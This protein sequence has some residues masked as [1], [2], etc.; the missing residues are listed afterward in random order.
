VEEEAEADSA[1]DTEQDDVQDHH[2]VVAGGAQGEE[3][4]DGAEG[5]GDGEVDDDRGD[6][7]AEHLNE[8]EAGSDERV[9]DVE[10]RERDEQG[11]DEEGGEL[12]HSGDELLPAL[13]GVL[14]PV[15][16]EGVPAHEEAV[17]GAEAD[18]HGH[19]AAEREACGLPVGVARERLRLREFTA[20]K[21]IEIFE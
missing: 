16:R 17:G 14:G 11:Q 3:A 20:E 15:E 10:R 2:E 9:E 21:T 19:K 7:E 12:D 5:C 8:A 4:E 1:G 6:E 18:R 13:A